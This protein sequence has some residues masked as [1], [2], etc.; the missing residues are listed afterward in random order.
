MSWRWNAA[1]LLAG[2]AN[3]LEPVDDQVLTFSGLPSNSGN[4]G[5]SP[6]PALGHGMARPLV[7]SQATKSIMN[8]YAQAIALVGFVAVAILGRPR[9]GRRRGISGAHA[10]MTARAGLDACSN[11]QQQSTRTEKSAQ[12]C[13]TAKAAKFRMPGLRPDHMHSLSCQPSRSD[14]FGSIVDGSPRPWKSRSWERGNV[15][16]DMI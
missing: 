1:I 13:G 8:R 5:P 4:N 7:V 14:M 2:I 9:V 12:T 16:A 6:E 10:R 3:A 15:H 11:L